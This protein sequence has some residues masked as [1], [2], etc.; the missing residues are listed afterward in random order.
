MG[1]I[2]FIVTV[3]VL[4]DNFY[5]SF[6]KLH[7]LRSSGFLPKLSDSEVITMEI[8]HEYLCFHKDKDI[9]KYFKHHWSDLFPRIPHRTNFVR[10]CANLWKIKEIFFEYLSSKQDQWIQIVDSMPIEVCKFVRAKHTKLFK[11]STNYGKWLGDTFFG[12]KLHMKINTFGMIRKY[13][14]VPASKGDITYVESLLENDQNC[15]VIPDKGYRSQPLHD[16]LWQENHIYFHTSLRRNNK[17]ISILPKQTIRKL[18]G[19]RRLIKTVNGQLEE[20][21]SIKKTTGCDLWHLMNRIIR[22]ILFHTLCVFLNLKL[23]RNPLNIKG[24]VAC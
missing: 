20:Q 10:Q 12:Y 5:K 23:K 19:I 22:K 9:Y 6:S 18:I 14:L 4:V 24:L 13:I 1:L 11:E 8:A 15:W 21:S 17:K 7:K 3:N 16:K 2:D